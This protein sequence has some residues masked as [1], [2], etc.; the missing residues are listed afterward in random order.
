MHKWF[1][2]EI[3]EELRREIDAAGGNE[4]FFCAYLNGGRID[5]IRVLAKGNKDSVP[6]VVRPEPG[7]TMVVLHNHP[8]GDLTPSGADITVASRLARE[9]IG[10]A[11]VNNEVNQCYIVVEPAEPQVTKEV[12]AREVEEILAPG[13]LIENFMSGFEVRPQQL[14]MAVSLA[15]ALNSRQHVLAE[16]GTGT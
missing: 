8:S 1:S 2:Q 4:V 15:Q 5:Q 3:S 12:T 14:E 10:F 6:A 16:A 7:K 11:I 13:G 9:G